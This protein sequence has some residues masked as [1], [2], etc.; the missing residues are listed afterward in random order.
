MQQLQI[1]IFKILRAYLLI[2]KENINTP[3]E[4]KK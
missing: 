2:W 3:K 4:K 1:N